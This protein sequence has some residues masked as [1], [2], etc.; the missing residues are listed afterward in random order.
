MDAARLH[1]HVISLLRDSPSHVTP[2]VGDSQDAATLHAELSERVHEEIEAVVFEEI[3]D[4]LLSLIRLANVGRDIA[5]E[6]QLLAL[7]GR[8]FDSCFL[9]SPLSLNF[10]SSRF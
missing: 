6:Q 1:T 7:R 8:V 4:L 9:L 3:G 5:Y 2:A 10:P